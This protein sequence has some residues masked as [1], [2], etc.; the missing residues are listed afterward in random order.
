MITILFSMTVK[1]ELRSDHAQEGDIRD[2]NRHHRRQF[3][4]DVLG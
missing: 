3:P 4:L 1:P 2:L